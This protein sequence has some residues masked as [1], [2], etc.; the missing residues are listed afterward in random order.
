M[1]A[2]GKGSSLNDRRAYEVVRVSG[3]SLFS[4]WSSRLILPKYA[5]HIALHVYHLQNIFVRKARKYSFETPFFGYLDI[6]R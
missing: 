2:I 6:V 3:R 1:L 4:L 5:L